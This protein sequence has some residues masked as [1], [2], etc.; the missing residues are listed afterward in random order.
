MIMGLAAITRPMEVVMHT[1][2]AY[3]EQAFTKGWL[4]Q[5]AAKRLAH[6][7]QA[8]RSRTRIC[9]SA[10]PRRPPATGSASG[11]CAATPAS[12]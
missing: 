10:W 1:D 3:V 12:S 9:G 4:E 5:L 8:G 11:A 2:S 6:R 7:R